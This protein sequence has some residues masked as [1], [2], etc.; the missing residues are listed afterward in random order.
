MLRANLRHRVW[1]YGPFTPLFSAGLVAL[2]FGLLMLVACGG[3]STAPSVE[4]SSE[5]S[6]VGEGA[7]PS[8]EEAGG[9][10]IRSPRVQWVPGMTMAAVYLEVVDQSGA[11]DRLLRV[12]TDFAK[13][14]ETHET[15]ADG[16]T[17]RMEARPDGFEVPAGGTLALEPGGKHIMLVEPI[18]PPEGSVFT[19]TLVFE[20]GG[21][22]TI[23]VEI[24][25]GSMDH[26]DHG[27]MDHGSMDHGGEA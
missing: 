19:L 2:L 8:A 14:A 20:R 25:G 4:P 23:E 26:G 13:A 16:E 15:L 11:G 1:W 17:L 21:P 10:E 9:L 18:P 7:A 3:E 22:R 27:S 5:G 12:E 24:L 6:P